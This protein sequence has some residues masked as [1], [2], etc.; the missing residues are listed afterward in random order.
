M[1]IIGWIGYAFPALLL[2]IP[3]VQEKIA[4]EAEKELSARL[5]VPVTVGKVDIEWLNRLVLGDVSINDPN[6][7]KLFEA[8]H[9][10]AGF[11]LSKITT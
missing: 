11:H 3:M 2:H 4:S 6:G 5:D 7:R 9:I 10:S 8:D 1:L